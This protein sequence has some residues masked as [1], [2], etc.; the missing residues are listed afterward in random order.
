LQEHD[1]QNAIRIAISENYLGTCFRVNVGQAW[2]GDRIERHSDGSVTIYNARPF[3]TGLPEGFSDLFVVLHGGLAAFLEVKSE[4]GR[5]SPN[6]LH[7]I[8]HMQQLG[9]KAG[10]VRS[11]SDALKLLRS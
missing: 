8:T 10:V 5:S 2:I 1:I 4:K 3:K 9:A 7:F 6:Q 11:V